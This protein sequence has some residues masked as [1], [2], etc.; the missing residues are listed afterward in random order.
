M[1]AFK[2]ERSLMRWSKLESSVAKATRYVG[3]LFNMYP[4]DRSS[5]SLMPT[6]FIP[7]MLSLVLTINAQALLKHILT[8]SDKLVLSYFS[9]SLAAQGGYAIA[10]N[11]GTR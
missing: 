5:H 6:Y 8:E 4:I 2:K 9:V 3:Q 11:Y 7:H 1:A 10:A